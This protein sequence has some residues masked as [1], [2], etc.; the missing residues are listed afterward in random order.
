MERR[1]FFKT[2]NLD[3]WIFNANAPVEKPTSSIHT[4]QFSYNKS[5]SFHPILHRRTPLPGVM[6]PEFS[7]RTA[8]EHSP[9]QGGDA[10]IVLLAWEFQSTSGIPVPVRLRSIGILKIRISPWN[11]EFRKFSLFIDCPGRSRRS[12]LGPHCPR[13]KLNT[14]AR[15]YIPQRGELVLRARL[16]RR[17][18]STCRGFT[19]QHVSYGEM[20]ATSSHM[21]DIHDVHG[22]DTGEGGPRVGHRAA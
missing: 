12:H 16:L 9:H 14:E 2:P 20:N 1:A 11:S 3:C 7:P 18:C 22:S 6:T 5:L 10:H 8:H 19:F 21:Q 17:V 4:N 15:A 13:T